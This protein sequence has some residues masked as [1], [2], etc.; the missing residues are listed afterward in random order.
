MFANVLKELGD[1]Q[2]RMQ[3]YASLFSDSARLRDVLAGVYIDLMG[4]CILATDL[5]RGKCEYQF[6]KQ[7]LLEKSEALLRATLMKK[8]RIFGDT[9]WT[10]SLPL[11]R[12]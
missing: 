4:F 1:H 8:N 6:P 12:K 9:P 7:G 10:F 3:L 5:F 11:S 2:P